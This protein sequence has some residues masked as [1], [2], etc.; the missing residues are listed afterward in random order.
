MFR[1]DN[2]YNNFIPEQR[3]NQS[4]DKYLKSI[5]EEHH[6][7]SPT[8]SYFNCAE[9]DDPK[10]GLFIYFKHLVE[11][12]IKFTVFDIGSHVGEARQDDR[13][14]RR[15][16][17]NLPDVTADRPIRIDDGIPVERDRLHDRRAGC[18]GDQRRRRRRRLRDCLEREA[19]H[20]KDDCQQR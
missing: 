14:E 17:S 8:I 1:N 20:E 5:N 16:R 13:G 11:H 12:D 7:P 18:G 6:Y 4:A 3:K 9:K 15:R 10:S 2:L 19:H